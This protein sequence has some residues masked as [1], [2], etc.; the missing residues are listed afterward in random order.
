[1]KIKQS[2]GLFQP[3]KK[4]S[5]LL[6]RGFV[7][8]LCETVLGIVPNN[9][10]SQE[11]VVIDTEKV[12]TVD[13]VFRII[14]KQTD[15][16]FIYQED[17]FK[18][19]PAVQ[20][21]KGEIAVDLLLQKVLSRGQFTY[22]VK[23]NNI[24]LIEKKMDGVRT[25][26]QDPILITGKVTDETGES[27]PGANVVEKGTTN[28]VI[29]DFEGNFSLR[30]PDE[31]TVLLISYVGYVTQEVV[32]G[33][34]TRIDIQLVADLS[35]LSEVVVTAL[36]LER[37]T[38]TVGYAVQTMK[39][40]DIALSAEP[41]LVRA[42]TGKIAGLQISGGTSGMAGSANILI[43]GNNNLNGNNLPL[44]IIDDVP[45][46]NDEDETQ[47]F[48]DANRTRGQVDYGDP[49]SKINP[50]DI[51]EISVLKGAGATALYGSRA[52]NGVILITTKKG[53]GL[54]K[55]RI[56]IDYTLNTT[57]SNPVMAQDFQQEYGA[58]ENG[59]YVYTGD[60]NNP[61]ASEF[62]PNSWG[63][64]FGENIFIRQVNSP[65]VNG[66]LVPVPWQ[67]HPD[68]LADFMRTGINMQHNL[69]F[70]F[71][72]DVA[73]GRISIAHADESGMVPETDEKRTN[74]NSNILANLSD[75]WKTELTVN[76]TESAS[77]NRVPGFGQG[78]VQ[79]IMRMPSSIDMR[80]INSVPHKR[81]DGSEFRFTGFANPYWVLK[82]DFN[83]YKRRNI[84]GRFGLRYDV[85]D[86]MEARI[87][88][89][90]NYS[91]GE[92]NNFEEIDQGLTDAG[93]FFN[94]G[95]YAIRTNTYTENN[96]DFM[97][98]GRRDI[99][100]DFNFSFTAGAN[101]RE[102]Y[103]VNWNASVNQLASP[104]IPNLSNG[105]G[106]RNVSQTFSEKLMQ[107]LFGIVSLGYKDFLFADFTG[108]NDWSSAL[109]KENWSYFYPST[110]LSFV[111]T[112]ALN[113]DS[114]VLS[115]A[116]LRASWSQVGSDTDPYQLAGTFGTGRDWNGK[117]TTSYTGTL[118]PTNLKPQRINSL[119]FG[120]EVNLFGNRV[121]LDVSYY[122]TNARN[123]IIT[124]NIPRFTG[125]SRARINAGNIENE[126]LELMVNVVPVEIR[127]FQWTVSV[128]AAK[129][130]TR[131][132]D[133]HD[134][135]DFV[136][137]GWL[138]LETRV[139]E[140]ERYGEIYG[141]SYV[142]NDEGRKIIQDNGN[143][144]RSQDYPDMDWDQHIGNA[145]PDW[146]GG[147]TNSFRYKDFSLSATISARFGG[148]VYSH[149]NVENMRRGLLQETVGLNDRGVDKRL[150]V[151][152]GGGMRYDGIKEV[153]DVSGNVTGYVENDTYLSA[154]DY[155][156][157]EAGIHERH[158]FDASFIKLQDVSLT[159]RV[160]SQLIR[161]L[162]YVKGATISMF[163]FNLGVLRSS[164]PN[165]DPEV[166][167]GR[168]NAGQGLESGAVPAARRLG[169][170]LNVRF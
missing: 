168:H 78:M 153:K 18:E 103:S 37:E 133:L 141:Y 79:N 3:W 159:Y 36:G 54:K 130:E 60:R 161:P 150:P 48:W 16:R 47:S 53:T 15:Y 102:T 12:V 55:G 152:Q 41:N 39:G 146:V 44:F 67:A 83:S 120:T 56:G 91:N 33:N 123:Q 34:Q 50:E 13:E 160:P 156:N 73:S 23:P 97:L 95:G 76:Y 1:M 107:S 49:I 71:N 126:G 138:S 104:G 38:K 70:S 105:L 166:S 10:F 108:R 19:L 85:T 142:Y 148:Q 143:A 87:A 167:L 93:T 24:I 144:Y 109:P 63:P 139:T 112:E 101:R 92:Y 145:Q 165:V 94:D 115:F 99:S 43:R 154:E 32:V 26:K 64:K 51:E 25:P 162:K 65:R 137:V 30:V 45:L 122:K 8:L 88:V 7:L 68:N 4:L 127:D 52:S 158:I 89:S 140:G 116:K 135:V 118:P 117:Q 128:N 59:V 42:L 46:F 2:N 74:L 131:L 82:E 14:K 61:G 35:E 57:F 147:I 124:V 149:S 90:K 62:T 119:E 28:G 17:M 169:F 129:N 77:D 96:Y 132:I 106:T 121:S 20:L 81:P 29:T 136:R 27:L 125:Y 21:K 98:I 66:E 84:V 170:R 11:K 31:S 6:M 113:V 72:G 100:D 157:W 86:W 110:S 80:Y 9:T 40:E 114:R 5:K 75:R 163:A 151:S 164:I 69:A 111:V 155:Y 22:V 134:D 58:G